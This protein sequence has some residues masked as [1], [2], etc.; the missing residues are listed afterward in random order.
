M[1]RVLTGQDKSSFNFS[2]KYLQENFKTIY[3][4][5]LQ[6]IIRLAEKIPNG[7]LVITPSYKV[8]NSLE[9]CMQYNPHLKKQLSNVK[10]IFTETRDDF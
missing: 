7:I 3:Q 10:K 9:R 2:Y 4:F 8:M 5:T 1:L 6:S